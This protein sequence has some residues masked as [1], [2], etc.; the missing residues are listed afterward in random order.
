MM[1]DVDLDRVRRVIEAIDKVREIGRDIDDMR[2]TIAQQR[3]LLQAMVSAHHA[4]PIT[5][6]MWRAWSA[7]E[8]Y[9]NG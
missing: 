8:S 4:G 3:Q 9:L 2:Q 1:A 5:D 6:E 7:A